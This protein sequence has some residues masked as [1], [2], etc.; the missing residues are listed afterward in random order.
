MGSNDSR[1]AEI[2]QLMTDFPSCWKVIRQTTIKNHRDECSYRLTNGGM[3]CDCAAREAFIATIEFA[4]RI[5]QSERLAERK[6]VLDKVKDR[7]ESLNKRANVDRIEFE[8]ILEAVES[9]LAE[10]DK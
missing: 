3:L 10:E 5:V 6:R 1:E 7:Y 4:N 8:G 2:E 9:E